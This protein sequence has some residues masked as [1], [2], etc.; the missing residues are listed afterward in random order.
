MRP[1]H[2]L[3]HCAHL[4]WVDHYDQNPRVEREQFKCPRC[5]KLT[6]KIVPHKG[7]AGAAYCSNCRIEFAVIPTWHERLMELETH[8]PGKVIR[9]DSN[10]LTFTLTAS[11]TASNINT[12]TIGSGNGITNW[13]LA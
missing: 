13:N 11:N 3:R 12:F 9:D 4:D 2:P 10:T 1:E 6:T 5:Y 8:K 7:Q